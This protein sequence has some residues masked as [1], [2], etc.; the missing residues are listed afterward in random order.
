MQIE[1]VEY[2][3][4]KDVYNPGDVINVAI[5]FRDR[6]IGECEAGLVRR[7]GDPPDDF[8]RSVFARSS[9]R[10]YEGQAQVRDDLAGP[11]VLA[12]RLTP[13]AAS[14]RTLLAGDQIFEVRLV[15]P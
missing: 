8:R 7:D 1:R 5:Y 6:F 13:V 3:P 11:C 4:R 15:R 10:L 2:S 14:P 12:V 9:D